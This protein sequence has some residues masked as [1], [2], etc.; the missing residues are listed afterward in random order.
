MKY[1]SDQFGSAVQV[2]STPNLLSTLA[3][4][5]GGKEELE[6]KQV[7]LRNNKNI[8]VLSVFSCKSQKTALCGFLKKTTLMQAG[9]GRTVYLA[10][11]LSLNW[12]VGADNTGVIK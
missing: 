4:L 6:R 9:H 2:V 7:L 12:L 5:L 3:C 10:A 1:S 11:N 8:S